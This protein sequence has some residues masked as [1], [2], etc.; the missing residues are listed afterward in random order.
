MA[1]SKKG[2]RD[3]CRPTMVAIDLSF[4][5]V[6]DDSISLDFLPLPQSHRSLRPSLGVARRCGV[7]DAFG[8]FCVCVSCCFVDFSSRMRIDGFRDAVA[9][10][11]DGEMATS[12]GHLRDAARAF[13]LGLRRLAPCGGA[14]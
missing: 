13:Q 4:L 12:A 14:I 8:V 7:A 3:K 9:L 6:S 10:I 1:D 5:K 2:R 11:L